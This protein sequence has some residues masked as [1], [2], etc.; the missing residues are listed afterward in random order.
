MDAQTLLNNGDMY[1]ST[2]DAVTAIN[3]ILDALHDMDLFKGHESETLAWGV[4]YLATK[5]NIALDEVTTEFNDV[6][7]LAQNEVYKSI[8]EDIATLLRNNEILTYNELLDFIKNKEFNTTEF[9]NNDNVNALLDILD[10]IVDVE[11]IDAIVPLVVKYGITL[12]DDKTGINASYINEFT[13]EE[14]NHDFHK[15]V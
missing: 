10:Q 15:L 7:W 14:L 12:V 11:V 6:N 4:N 5:L 9:I 13:S 3:S 1:I 8:V 2:P